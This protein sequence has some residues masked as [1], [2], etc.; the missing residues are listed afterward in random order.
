MIEYK[1]G[2][3]CIDWSQLTSLY[4]LVGMVG[5]LGEQGDREGIKTAFSEVLRLLQ[6]GMKTG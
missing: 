2:I 1:T 5:G 4:L 3:D 6:P